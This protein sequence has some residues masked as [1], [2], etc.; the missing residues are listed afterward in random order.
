VPPAS[1][2]AERLR[3]RARGTEF[4]A[5]AWGDPDAPLVLCLHGF[6]DTA[7]TWR[8][9]GP[10][11]AA[12]GRRVVAPF[13]R[14]YAPTALAPDDDYSAAA[15]ARDAAA[16]RDALGGG[17]DAALVGHDWGAVVAYAMRPGTFARVVAMAVPPPPTLARLPP[18][19]AVRQA[20]RSWYMAFNQ[21]PEVSDRAALRLAAHLWRAWSPGHD[22]AEDL[23]RLRE[24]WPTQ[25]HRRAALR[26]YRALR[27]WHLARTPAPRDVLYLHGGDD[28][29]VLPAVA[30]RG[31]AELVP[32]AGHFLQLERPDAVNARI[33]A[34]LGV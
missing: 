34:H 24:S 27:P 7:W 15:L 32:G 14:G 33:A 6:P 28:G 8:H 11:L 10:H 1:P 2:A 23:E 17:P 13:M 16:L 31:G 29:C 5:L 4:A 30:R 25:A 20:R 26:Y 19:L 18:L 22:P 9:L 21:L 12:R 3:L